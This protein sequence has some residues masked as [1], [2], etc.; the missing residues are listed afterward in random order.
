MG[1]ITTKEEIELHTF[2]S[3][4]AI[5]FIL[6]DTNLILYCGRYDRILN[7]HGVEKNVAIS[8]QKLHIRFSSFGD[9]HECSGN[10]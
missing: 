3:S 1:V 2:L 10:L 6:P 5:A 9:A 4:N 7:I 8:S